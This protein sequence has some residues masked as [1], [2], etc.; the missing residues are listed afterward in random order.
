MN[1]NCTEELA[2]V[3]EL[4][5][6]L[7][8]ETSN[9]PII[10]TDQNSSG[11]TFT[12]EMVSVAATIKPDSINATVNKKQGPEGVI[13]QISIKMQFITRSEALE[14][15]LDQYENKPGVVLSKMNNEFQKLYGTDNEPLYMTYEVNEGDKIDGDSATVIEIKGET[16]TRPVYYTVL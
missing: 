13:Y 7:L 16:R 8:T 3:A 9:W 4:D 1:F 10:L 12:P 5:F 15:L 11:V 14:Q 6:F 2:G